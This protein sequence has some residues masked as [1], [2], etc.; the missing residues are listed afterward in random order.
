AVRALELGLGMPQQGYNIFISGLAGAGVRAQIEGLLRTTAATLPTPGDWVYVHNFRSPDQPQALPLEA[1]QGQRLQH[2][3]ERLVT[4]IRETLP[5]AFRQEVFEKEQREL[6]EKYEREMRQMQEAFARL[7][8]DNGFG[9]Q[10]DAA[11]NVAFIPLRGDRPM[12]PEEVEHLSDEQRQDLERRQNL[13]LQ[14]FRAVMLRQRQLMQQLATD[15][16]EVERNFSALLIAPLIADLKERHPQERVQRYFDAVQEHMLAHLELFKEGAPQAPA[17]MPPFMA[18]PNER[19]LFLEYTVNVVVDNSEVQGAPVII[20]DMPSYKNL[21]GTIDRVVDPHGRVVTN[22]SRIKAGSLLR[23]SGGYVLLN[24]EDA[25]T[26]PLVWKTLKRTLQGNRMQIETYDP[27]AFFTIS[28]LQPEPIAIQT[29][30]VVMGQPWLYYLLYFN[31]PDFAQIFKVRADFGEDMDNS[32]EHQASYAYFI[33]GLCRQ[34]S[35]RHF[36]RSGVEAVLEYGMRSV[37]DQEKLVSQLG[38]LADVVREASYAAGQAG[39]TVVSRAHVVQAL[40][41]RIFRANRS[42][43]RLQEFVQ[44]GT[45][46]LDTT[47]RQVGQ[48]NGLS[49]LQLGDYSFGRPARVTATTSMGT[50]GIVNIERE[51]KLSGSTHDKGVL[52]LSGYLRQMYAQDKPLTLAASL[53]FEQSYSGIDGDSAS[54]TEL[55]ALLSR[56]ANVPLRQDLA[57]TGSVNQRGEV[58]AIGGVNEKIEGFFDVCMQ[59]VLTGEQGVLIPQANV[60]NL[61]LRHDVVEAIA[62][63]R[64]HV[65]P[66]T[67]IDQGLALL[68]SMPAGDTA[69]EGTLHYLVNTRL[70]QL[71]KDIAAF[72]RNGTASSTPI[73]E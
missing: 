12:T 33:A 3:M 39:A 59:R 8:R 17:G 35:L 36:D 6:G 16:R 42:E 45:I 29:K 72:G 60:R 18:A 1:G 25:L 30:V 48:I 46:L 20:E 37:A 56:L 49:V 7:A 50:G 61:M 57:V 9:L 64:F 58:Q 51:A 14:E 47:G 4:H 2:D 19:E 41:D 69:T 67:H 43:K 38:V 10:A 62:A 53:C 22:F 11:G 21:F 71:A 5:K 23:A 65:Y 15:I 54:S 52:I 26:E 66:I 24:L 31:D 27:F 55:Y 68:T 40:Q 73:P 44:S 34:E 63:G 28:A 32:A 13:V 70:Q